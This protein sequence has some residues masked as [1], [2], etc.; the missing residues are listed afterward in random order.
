ME[1]PFPLERK[2]REGPVTNIKSKQIS[3]K[4]TAPPPPSHSFLEPVTGI[5]EGP[6][7][8][9]TLRTQPCT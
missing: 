8:K 7:R 3:S 4:Q 2:R 1:W 5:L 6:G 9:R